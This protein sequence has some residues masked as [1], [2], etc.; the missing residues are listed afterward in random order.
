VLSIQLRASFKMHYICA[1]ERDSRGS[2]SFPLLVGNWEM[3]GE[4]SCNSVKTTAVLIY[5]ARTA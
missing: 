1:A 4:S 3:P 2:G 5:I